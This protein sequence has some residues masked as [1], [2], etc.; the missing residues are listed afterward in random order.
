MDIKSLNK[1]LLE[2]AE[3]KNRLSELN[4]ND[5]TYDEIEEELHDLEDDFG[6]KFGDYVE[7]ALHYVHDEYCPDN[8]VLLPIAYL[9][10]KYIEKGKLADGS[11]EYDV[12]PNEG[13]IVDVDD[14]P[15]KES[16]LVLVPNPTRLI[17][18]VGRNQK[19]EVWHAG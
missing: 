14:Y 19:E 9:A 7:D 10:N 8:D 12:E 16:R 13:V 4:Y 15:G 17:L 18:Q 5:S 2:I 6:E 3:K 1:A 11:V